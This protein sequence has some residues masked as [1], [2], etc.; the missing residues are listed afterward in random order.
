MDDGFILVGWEP[1]FGKNFVDTMDYLASNWMLPLGGLFI[2]I[3]AGWFMPKKIRAAELQGAGAT[4]VMAWFLLI[5]YVAPLLVTLVAAFALSATPRALRTPSA[6]PGVLHELGPPLREFLHRLA[7]L[8][9]QEEKIVR[10]P[11][12]R[13]TSVDSGA[14]RC[15]PSPC[16]RS[17]HTGHVP[18][19][20]GMSRHSARPHA[21]GVWPSVTYSPLDPPDRVGGDGTQ[22]GE[23]TNEAEGRGISYF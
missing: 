15:G 1:S 13:V 23:M 2:A 20:G 21:A 18:G 14:A 22:S 11:Q 19:R 12:S 10:G 4:I 9:P 16:L 6:A 5:R 7:G 17:R 3:Y 8:G